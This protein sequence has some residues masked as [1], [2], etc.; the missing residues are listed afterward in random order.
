MM[1]FRIQRMSNASVVAPYVFPAFSAIVMFVRPA[2][3]CISFARVFRSHCAASTE[4][5]RAARKAGRHLFVGGLTDQISN[6]EVQDALEMAGDDEKGDL[7]FFR[8]V[9]FGYGFCAYH[10][11]AARR[12]ALDNQLRI[13]TG[14]LK[15]QVPHGTQSV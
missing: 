14:V 8:R 12:F 11:K 9:D 5:E 2:R 13:S 10:T 6:E 15:I 4:I 3:V 1:I 7:E